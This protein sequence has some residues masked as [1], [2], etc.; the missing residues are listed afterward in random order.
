[1]AETHAAVVVAPDKFKGSL[2]AAEAARHIAVGL[3][4]VLPDLEV[5]LA[6]VA[7]G[8]DGTVDALVASGFRRVEV[9]VAGP[10]GQPVDA[11]Y[12]RRDDTAV[13]E[14]AEASGMRRL[15]GGRTD[16]MGSSTRGTGDLI[17]AALEAGCRRLVLG[18]GGSASTDGGAGMLQALGVRLLDDRGHEIGPG[19]RGLQNLTSVELDR[20]DPRLAGT[21]M[22]LASDVDNPL[23]GAEGAAAVY[24]PQKGANAEQ[25][26]ELEDGLRRWSDL[27]GSVIGQ[28][29]AGAPGAGAAGGVGYAALAMLAAKRRP[30]VEVVLELIGFDDLV[31]GA[32]LVITG[33]GALDDQTLRGKAPMGVARAAGRQGVPAVAVA[34]RSALSAGHLE[35]AGLAAAYPL[36]LLEPD[37][38][39]CLRDAGRLLEEL[40]ATVLAPAWLMRG[41][42]S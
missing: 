31:T 14:L 6:P 42:A 12:A 17:L 21:T 2:T 35:S 13:I 39:I 41:A 34:G 28:G 7:D 16:P 25:V 3:R 32:R 15:P 37:P 5:R 18:V 4:A 11:S 38:T 9:T 20:L 10:T 19:G 40:T 26:A 33:E 30:G 27:V 8:G 1:M 22:M 23:L 29:L 36:G 24:A